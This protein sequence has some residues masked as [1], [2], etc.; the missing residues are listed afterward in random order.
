[1]SNGEAARRG[2]ACGSI[3]CRP[4]LL[5][6]LCLAA[7]LLF[8]ARRSI[9]LAWADWLAARGT[10]EGVKA[11][12]QVEPR[13]AHYW[14][15]LAALERAEGHRPRE[16]L[17]QAVAASP[18]DARWRLELALQAEL[19][20]QLDAAEQHLLRAAQLSRKFAPRWA[21]VNFYYRHGPE[22]NFWL[23]VREALRVSYGD[24]RPLFE[25]CW[26]VRPEPRI[27][28]EQAVPENA[29]LQLAFARF[30]V[31]KNRSQQAAEVVA[32]LAGNLAGQY[33]LE[34]LQLIGA[35]L[36]HG[37]LR[38]ARYLWEMLCREHLVPYPPS[39]GN[40]GLVS[41]NGEFAHRPLNAGFDWKLRSVAG[42]MAGFEPGRL[43]MEFDGR[44]PERCLLL[45]QWVVLGP[46][47]YLFESE[48][49]L[50]RAPAA[51]RDASPGLI[52]R[53]QMRGELRPWLLE[54][55]LQPAEGRQRV[56]VPFRVAGVER[57]GR[58]ELWYERPSG[59]PR[60]RGELRLFRARIVRAGVP[61]PAV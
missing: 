27:I 31:E 59:S 48:Y 38:G 53:V 14:V 36:D 21:L 35:L 51:S 54:L 41:V 25:L 39:D 13:A 20:G 24:R 43:W 61:V 9:R 16:A 17:E 10:L 55:V 44:Q 30:L 5:V 29:A 8:A 37:E 12:V 18:W 15:R 45:E 7:L 34:A 57:G 26:A 33:T 4:A 3:P 47:N 28:F 1:M 6:W 40:A 60:F 52:W 49:E 56:R 11:A 58:L 2:K 32:Q 22:E 46:G 50:A 42:V 19:E 23:W